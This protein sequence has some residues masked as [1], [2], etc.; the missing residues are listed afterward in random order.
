MRS[1]YYFY[2]STLLAFYLIMTTIDLKRSPSGAY[3]QWRGENIYYVQAGERAEN[4][5]VLLLIHGFG[6]STAHWRKNIQELSQDFEV[7]AVDLVGFG[8]SA[9]PSWSYSAQL[10]QEQLIEFITTK[11]DRPVILAGNSLGGY[12]T[13][14]VAA[15]APDLI[16]GLIL[17]NSAGPFTNSTHPR[18]PNLIQKAISKAIVGILRNP[19]GNLALFNFIRRPSFIRKTL[20]K[21]YIDRTAVTDR[22]VEEIYLPSCDPGAPAVFASIFNNQ[23]GEKVDVLLSRIKCPLLM[24]WGELDPWIDARSRNAKFREHYHQM[25]EIYLPAGHCPHDEVPQ[26]VNS[27]IRDRISRWA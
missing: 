16:R 5:A 14:C 26:L 27:A 8:K 4:R 24:L 7:W 9:K 21:L 11:I 17:L 1:P 18:E 25:E 19:L 22:L 10:W 15:A 6:G 20:H 12:I 3:W 2:H 13:L 23:Q